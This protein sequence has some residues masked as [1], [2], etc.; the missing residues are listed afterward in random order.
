MGANG[1]YSGVS[2]ERQT[3][4]SQMPA[5]LAVRVAF[6]TRVSTTDQNCEFQL[7]ELQDGALSQGWQAVELHQDIMSGAQTRLP[8]LSQLMAYAASRKF[9]CLMV[10]KL[11]RF[12]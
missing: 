3:S 7:R 10:W 4:E 12:G 5:A 1:L 8:G 2:S 9:N 6:Y 11:D